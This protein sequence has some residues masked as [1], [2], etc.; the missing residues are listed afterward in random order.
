[1]TDQSSLAVDIALTQERGETVDK[2][3]LALNRAVNRLHESNPMMGLRGVRLGVLIPD[4]FSMQVRAL[5]RAALHVRA[6]GYDPQPEI[7]IPLVAVLCWWALKKRYGH[8]VVA[9]E[10]DGK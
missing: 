2:R 7:M 3:K 6:Q 8:P 10:G 4:L 9:T 1:M 5:T